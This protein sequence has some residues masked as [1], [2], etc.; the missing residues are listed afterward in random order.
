MVDQSLRVLQFRGQTGAFLEPASGEPTLNL[1]KMAR[2]GLIYALRTATHEARR[3]GHPVRREG[4]RIRDQ[5]GWHRVNVEVLPLE[6]S[7]TGHLLVLF[8]QAGASGG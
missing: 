5:K 4:V 3:L 7:S 1:L 6:G 2:E 8:E